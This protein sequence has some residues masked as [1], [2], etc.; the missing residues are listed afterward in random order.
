MKKLSNSD[1][2]SLKK[3]VHTF[4]E[5]VLEGSYDKYKKIEAFVNSD[6]MRGE[7][8]E[9]VFGYYNSVHK[10]LLNKM[11]NV[12]AEIEQGA[13]HVEEAFL[14][15]ESKEDGLVD[16]SCIDERK[17]T[18]NKVLNDFETHESELKNVESNILHIAG[19]KQTNSEVVIG[20]FHDSD[21]VMHDIIEKLGDKDEDLCSELNDLEERVSE[22]KTAITDI[23][24]NF[25]TDGGF[26]DEKVNEI[27]N[28]DWYSD[29]K[30]DEFDK[31]YQ[32]SPFET[33]QHEESSYTDEVGL[34][35]DLGTNTYSV[36]AN[37]RG[38]DYTQDGDVFSGSAYYT[39]LEAR[40]DFK[41]KYAQSSAAAKVLSAEGNLMTEN[42]GIQMDGNVSAAKVEA[43][44]MV[45]WDDWNVHADGDAGVLTADGDARVDTHG[46]G[47]NGDVSLASAEANAGTT[48]AG[49]DVDAGVDI[50]KVGG[51][52]EVSADKVEVE[53]HFIVGGK[54]SIDFP[55]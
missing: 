26:S 21:T 36:S 35:T 23:D 42:H 8:G 39:G 27:K 41:L 11:M 5:G 15:Y 12:A 47:V 40:G 53:L 4:K 51:G 37:K 2:A 55:W 52:F 6:V 10:H 14:S 29:E 3:N 34:V 25:K 7:S 48:I 20:Q 43:D 16:T 13:N 19:V 50:G 44:T 33:G 1:I 17:G 46:V 22:L 49:T 24:N 31:M 30:T 18:V 28:N 38:Y 9:S 54:L 32:E 45:G